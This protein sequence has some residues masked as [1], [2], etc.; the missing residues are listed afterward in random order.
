MSSAQKVA[1]IT[2]A[3]RGLG[4]ADALHPAEAGVD[5]V[6]TYRGNKAQADEVV[7]AV[8]AAGRTAVDRARLH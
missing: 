2:G 8:T 7:A 6:V 5:V 1:V 4:R 3:N